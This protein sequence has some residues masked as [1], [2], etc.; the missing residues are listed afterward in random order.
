MDPADRGL[1]RHLDRVVLR[2]GSSH[3]GRD[4]PLDQGIGPI[5]QSKHYPGTIGMSKVD[6]S[7]APIASSDVELGRDGRLSNLA[8]AERVGLSPSACLRRVTALERA[9][10]IRGYTRTI[11]LQ[12]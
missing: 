10:V 12:V 11:L 4:Q 9:G 1:V 5:D 3:F 7:R 2:A 8:L 6:R